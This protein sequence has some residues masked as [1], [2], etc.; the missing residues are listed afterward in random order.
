MPVVIRVS[1]HTYENSNKGKV[2]ALRDLL[3]ESHYAKVFYINYY[4]DFYMKDA[5]LLNWDYETPEHFDYNVLAEDVRKEICPNLMARALREICDQAHGVLTSLF[6]KKR[7]ILREIEFIKSLNEE[8]IY[9]GEPLKDYSALE[10][11]F[12]NTIISKPEIKIEDAS[13]ELCSLTLEFIDRYDP[14]INFEH[15]IEEQKFSTLLNNLS[16]ETKKPKIKALNKNIHKH[17]AFSGQTHFDTFLKIS[18]V[19]GSPIY[20]PVSYSKMDHKFIKAGAR[21]MSG[22]LLRMNSFDLRYEFNVKLKKNGIIVGGDTGMKTILTLSDGQATKFGDELISV[23]EEMSK[24]TKG[25]LRF[26][27]L[28]DERENLI[29]RAING[30]DFSKIKVLRLEHIDNLFYKNRVSAKMARFTNALIERKILAKC[31]IEGVLCILLDSRYKSQRCCECG[32]VKKSHRNKKN[33]KC[34]NPLCKNH[35]VVIDADFN[36]AK[37]N[38]L[39]LPEIPKAISGLKLNRKGFYWLPN[40]VFEVDSLGGVGKAITDDV[41]AVQPQPK[42]VKVERNTSAKS[43][44]R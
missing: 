5:D 34:S 1:K 25:T 9:K 10:K 6:N 40:G 37:N 44:I 23:M 30:L 12:D 2:R 18:L 19:E 13:L 4:W 33:Y 15:R 28:Q 41:F 31:E 35:G 14:K 20:I 29:N 22:V 11:K 36:S 43:R 26:A 16:N 7:N 21:R 42:T 3:L 17:A 27:Q 24:T 8:A 32:M 38:A 39:D